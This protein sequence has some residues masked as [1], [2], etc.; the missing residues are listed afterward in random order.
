[1]CERN[2]LRCKR[3]SRVGCGE[4]NL[5][6]REVLVWREGDVLTVLGTRQGEDDGSGCDAQRNDEHSDEV[7]PEPEHVS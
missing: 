5:G 3:A 4:F 6:V 1:V 2:V 7:T